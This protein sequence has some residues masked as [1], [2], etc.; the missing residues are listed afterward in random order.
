MSSVCI[1]SPHQD[2][3]KQAETKSSAFRPDIEGLRG[4]AVLLVVAFHV[5]IPGVSGGFLG[6]D[7]FFVLSGYLIT[8]ILVKE[9]NKSGKIRFVQFYA[10][11]VRRLLPASALTVISVLI[12]GVLL[13]SPLEMIGLSK[14]AF[15]TSA[16][17][18]NL[19]FMHQAANYFAPEIET[20]PLLHTWS[21]AVEEQ[22]YVMWPLIILLAFR[23]GSRRRLAIWMG[24]VSAISFALCIWLTQTRQ[25]W[26]FFGTPARA[27]EFGLGGL[28]ALLSAAHLKQYARL[29]A[30]IEWPAL[31]GTLAAAC[32]FSPRIRFPG[33]AAMLPVLGTA[34]LLIAGL[35]HP[36]KSIPRM[37]STPVLVFLGS[38]S[39]SWYLWHWPLLVFVSI[40]IPYVPLLDRIG[41]AVISLAIAF[42]TSRFFEDPLRYKT[43]LVQRPRLSLA[44]GMLVTI[45]GMSVALLCHKASV[46]EGST[47]LQVRFTSATHDW[48]PEIQSCTS[49]FGDAMVR[50][51][52]FGNLESAATVVLFGDSHAEQWFPALKR[53]AKQ[54]E[55][56]L[57]TLVK[58]SCPSISV[59]VFNPRIERIETECS[60]WRQKALARIKELHPIAVVIASSIGYVKG[61]GREDGYATLT[62]NQW[63][64]GTRSILSQ[65]N[66]DQIPAI[67]VRDTPRPGFNVPICLSRVASHGKNPAGACRI[68]QR[69]ALG[70]PTWNAEQRAAAGLPTV[71]TLDLTDQFCAGNS[72]SP[73]RDGIVVYRDTNHIT[74]S[75]STHLATI[76]GERAGLSFQQ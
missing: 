52:H 23:S 24:A 5:G 17:T 27:W 65:L 70:V 74:A 33:Y 46:T 58:S 67:L 61:P 8:G 76:F 29:W 12:A 49:F 10:R 60:A 73:M 66:D 38:V 30:W 35:I 62:N 71:K 18:S 32:Y 57:T 44:L 19:W 2:P 31:V 22:F 43:Y 68:D 26:A 21:L 69:L 4:I 45:C 6:V 25:P 11:R 16:Y 59:P 75:F 63:M 15:A 72:C 55:F 3:Q 9:M 48:D 51:C 56:K 34:I 14:T 53:I 37:L 1:E 40:F 20:N 42:L 41:I 47:P 7:I 64:D 39:Y 50:E 54:K 36:G 28:A 13:L